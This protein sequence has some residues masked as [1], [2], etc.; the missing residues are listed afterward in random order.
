MKR[1][2]DFFKSLVLTEI[3]LYLF[4]FFAVIGSFYV[5]QP[6]IYNGLRTHLLLRWVHNAS[7]ADSWWM[8][9]LIV[10]G[11]FLCVNTIVCSIDRL[12]IIIRSLLKPNLSFKSSYVGSLRETVE[13]PIKE[14]DTEQGMNKAEN[15]FSR[16]GYTFFRADSDGMFFARKGI[17]GILGP[18]IAHAGFL[19]FLLAHL[20]SASSGFKEHDVRFF[21]GE[22]TELS[23]VPFAVSA[24]RAQGDRFSVSVPMTAWEKDSNGKYTEKHKGASEINSPFS[25]DGV[26]F[27]YNKSERYLRSISLEVVFPGG[28]SKWVPIGF[29]EEKQVRGNIS[30][31]VGPLIPNYS[32]D[33]IDES[34]LANPAFLVTLKDGGRILG[35]MWFLPYQAEYTRGSVGKTNVFLRD[36]VIRDCVTMNV[37][38]NPGV[39]WALLGGVLFLLGM[40]FS[41]IVS[42]DRVWGLLKV[43]KDGG[44]VMQCGGVS[45]VNSYTFHRRVNKLL[46]KELS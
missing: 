1:I 37:I 35:S 31:L 5:V 27:Y 41:T 3:C 9:V 43:G 39:W 6:D 15:I 19:F 44:L 38:S 45:S 16:G 23:N 40:G 46:K 24:K 29:E 32:A 42:Y 17:C 30:V 21:P 11:V 22:K 26:Y 33:G 20:I 12:I 7:F 4:M 18:Y 13:I 10:I 25:Y 14:S 36:M 2:W 34:E 8:I 28:Y